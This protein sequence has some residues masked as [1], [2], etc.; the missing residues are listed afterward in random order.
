M[1]QMLMTQVDVQQIMMPPIDPL[2]FARGTLCSMSFVDTNTAR[3]VHVTRLQYQFDRAGI[4]ATMAGALETL[5]FL[6]EAEPLDNGYWIPTPT[7]V[8]D[9]SGGHCLLVGVNPT[10][11][12]RRHFSSVRRAGS[13]RVVA[14]DAV[15]NLP[16]QSLRAWRG[17]DGHD[18]S[19]WAR[20]VIESA[21]QQFAMSVMDEGVK[22]FGIKTS[23]GATGR[24][25]APVWVRPGDGAACNWRGVGLFRARTGAM[26]PRYFLGRHRGRSFLE[27]PSVQE[28]TRMQLGLAALQNQSLTIGIETSRDAVSISLPLRAP[29]ALR[30]L[31]VA[32]CD[33]VPQSYDRKW[34]C[35]TPEALPA[36]RASLQELESTTA[37]E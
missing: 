34:I 7:R 23:Q 18:A 29:V 36:L 33:A 9:L 6:R 15:V 4:V 20:T 27:G 8:V 10:A 19:A 13:A 21:M 37:H 11:E 14:A 17:H 31:L 25:Q 1:V 28:Q 22:T 30:R 2:E 26:S 12:L 3:E 5:K 16:K 32:L 24:S 35:R